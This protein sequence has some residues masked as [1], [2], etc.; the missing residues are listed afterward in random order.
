MCIIVS[1][2]IKERWV[3]KHYQALS[4][5]SMI[6]YWT[7]SFIFDVVKIEITMLTTLLMFDVYQTG[8]DDIWLVLIPASISLVLFSYVVSFCFKTS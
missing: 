5:L 7:N 4:G 1:Q 8:W 6:S 3:K 2:K